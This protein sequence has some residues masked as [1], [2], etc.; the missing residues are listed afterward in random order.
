MENGQEIRVH[1]G[2]IILSKV[3]LWILSRNR[4][5]NAWMVLPFP[6]PMKWGDDFSKPFQMTISITP[7]TD[8]FSFDPGKLFLWDNGRQKNI[9]KYIKSGTHSNGV[10]LLD[11]IPRSEVRGIRLQ[12]DITTTVTLEFDIL[13]PDPSEAF[14]LQLS[15]LSLFGQPYSVPQLRFE[16]DSFEGPLR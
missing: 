1:D 13:P 9:P 16:K 8:G 6:A 15:G 14:F 10:V 4:K 2:K 5:G 3:E 12:K 7:R 11:R